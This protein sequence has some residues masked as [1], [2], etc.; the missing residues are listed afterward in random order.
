MYHA[1]L[2]NNLNEL[3]GFVAL[4]HNILKVKY[5]LIQCFSLCCVGP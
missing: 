1:R 4:L 2:R 3:F 5:K